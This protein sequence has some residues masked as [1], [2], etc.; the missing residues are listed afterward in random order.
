M[1]RFSIIDLGGKKR[2]IPYLIKELRES[3]LISGTDKD[4]GGDTIYITNNILGV[5]R[6][7]QE[8]D[9]LMLDVHKEI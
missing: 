3:K 1:A 8:Y 4:I 7:V 2:D 9:G 6:I 5:K